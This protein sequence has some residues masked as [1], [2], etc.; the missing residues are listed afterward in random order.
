L[1]KGD[2]RGARWEGPGCGDSSLLVEVGFVV[3][4]G[5]LVA[6]EWEEEGWEVLPEPL[7]KLNRSIP[8]LTIHTLACTLT[9]HTHAHHTQPAAL[10]EKTRH[11]SSRQPSFPDSSLA[12]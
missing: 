2:Y 9:Q 4:A 7:Q 5:M 10:L 12:I 3:E 6:E 8:P 11:P 1:F